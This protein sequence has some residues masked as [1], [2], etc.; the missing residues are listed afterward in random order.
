MHELVAKPRIYVPG[1]AAGQPCYHRLHAGRGG[2][3]RIGHAKYLAPQS[4]VQVQWT[5]PPADRTGV[6][7]EDANASAG[8][9]RSKMSGTAV[10]PY[11]YQPRHFRAS[12]DEG[13]EVRGDL[14]CLLP[15]E[16]MVRPF[17][18]RCRGAR[19]LQIALCGEGH[20]MQAADMADDGRPF[21]GGLELYG[22]V[23]FAAGN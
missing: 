3:G 5:H 1:E 23:T 8:R 14:V 20:E 21:C 6:G 10:G 11:A 19:N 17:V 2:L 12:Q 9:N 15:Y 13:Q 22:Q 16:L 4:N 18:N 7:W